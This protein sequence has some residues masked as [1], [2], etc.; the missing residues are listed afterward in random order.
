MLP[1]S[2]KL[3][4]E[5]DAAT[6]GDWRLALHKSWEV[7]AA[8]NQIIADCGMIDCA[9]ADARL[10]AKAKVL[11]EEVLRLRADNAQINGLIMDRGIATNVMNEAIRERDA[12]RKEAQ[13]ETERCEKLRDVV[14]SCQER[15]ALHKRGWDNAREEAE[16]LRAQLADARKEA[17]TYFGRINAALAILD[18]PDDY[19]DGICRANE[20]LW[21]GQE[22]P[23]NQKQPTS[24]RDNLDDWHDI[25]G[26]VSHAEDRTA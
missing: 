7:E 13:E 20:A 6:P 26:G 12:A 8:P 3:Q 23:V 17:A 24:E 15:A 21:G 5:I 9:E 10:M 16:G 4:R 1:D 22:E 2:E 18:D 25:E 11:A 19:E 14:R